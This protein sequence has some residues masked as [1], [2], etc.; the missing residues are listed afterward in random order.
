MDLGLNGA[1]ALVTGGSS[2]IGQATARALARE[3]AIVVLTYRHNQE[4][5]DQTV[6][7][8][9]ADGGSAVAARYDLDDPA[10][11]TDLVQQVVADHGRLDLLVANAVAWPGSR[12]S[13]QD[14]RA[15]LRTNLEGAIHTVEQALPHLRAAQGRIVLISSSIATDGMPG[16]GVY[17]AAKA[18]LHGLAASLSAEH[19]PAGVLTNVV[20]PGLTLTDRAQQLIPDAVRQQVADTTATRRLTQPAD[21][22][23]VVTFLGSPTNRQITG[24]LV[25]VD[26][27]R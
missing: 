20:L 25:R 13:D 17:G 21:V 4:H 18:G 5:A 10:A 16:S 19:A 15:C 8:I 26:G 9:A 27:G 22:A 14:W 2:G 11:I 12:G 3:H 24:Q 23:R 1:V 6:A 7:Q